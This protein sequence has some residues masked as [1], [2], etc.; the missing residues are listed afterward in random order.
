MPAFLLI[1][2]ANAADRP[3]IWA[4]LAPTIRAGETYALPTDMSEADAVGYWM[5]PGHAVFMAEVEGRI[6]GTYY[7]RANQQGGGDHVANCAY[8]TDPAARGRGV[9][10]QMAEH[11]LEEARRR[12]FSA[13]QFNFVVASNAAAVNLWESVGFQVVGRLPGAFRHP[14]LGLV[15]ALIMFRQL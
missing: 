7:L 6:V 13:M 2:P 5:G 11:S 12:G 15:D 4:V 3:A 8:I 10:R 14:R 9:A 1:R